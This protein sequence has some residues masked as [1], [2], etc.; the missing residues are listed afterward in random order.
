MLHTAGFEI[1]T[2]PAFN[3][4]HT[5]YYFRITRRAILQIKKVWLACNKIQDN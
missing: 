2:Q 1:T 5:P 4:H 3:R